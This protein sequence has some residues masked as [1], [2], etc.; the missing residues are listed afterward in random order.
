MITLHCFGPGFG[1]PDPSLFNMKTMILMKMADQPFRITDCNV[2]KAPKQKSPFIVDDGKTIPDSTFIRFHLEEKYSVD[3]DAGLTDEQ[4]SIA[5][6]FEKLCEEHL[7]F[8]IL[9]E[10]WMVDSNFFKGPFKFFENVQ[11][12]IRPFIIS[13]IRGEIRRNLKGQGL[14]R[15]TRSEQMKLA[16]RSIEAL[17][18]QLGDK[19]YLIGAAPCSADA[20]VFPTIAGMAID[21]F[22]TDLHDLVHA[23]PNLIAY[24]DRCMTRW[25]PDF[26]PSA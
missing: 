14:G 12:A 10:R 3:F 1:L 24:R 20:V 19:D 8:I 25:F 26:D 15:H 23:H 16:K 22:Q 21:R 9:S 5:W 7:Y 4:K 2:R 17:A 18:G 13:K 6:A 11:G